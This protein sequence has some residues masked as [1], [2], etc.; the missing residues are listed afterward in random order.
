MVS[1]IKAVVVIS[2]GTRAGLQRQAVPEKA[3]E[4]GGEGG[5]D[6]IDDDDVL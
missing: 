1:Q 3:L 2:P 6:D 5:E 4:M